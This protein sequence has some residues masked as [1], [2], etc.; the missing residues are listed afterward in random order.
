MKIL[1]DGSVFTELRR[2]KLV[3][4]WTAVL[5]SLST[6]QNSISVYLL[7]RELSSKF[8]RLA[9][10]INLYAPQVEWERSAL[11]D[12][13]LALLCKELGVDVFVSTYYTSAGAQV[14]SL[15]VSYDDL[16]FWQ[17][18]K[19]EWQALSEKRARNLACATWIVPN[20]WRWEKASAVTQFIDKLY[21]AHDTPLSAK[22]LERRALEEDL[23]IHQA[24][25][26]R[27]VAIQSAGTSAHHKNRKAP[28]TSFV[29]RLFKAVA[30]PRCYPEYGYR[31]ICKVREKW[32]RS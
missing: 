29:P 10:V 2:G 28:T 7:N 24:N 32:F 5:T 25:A 4:F 18:P 19:T 8:A 17:D 15:A 11:E 16:V 14:R 30:R 12:R 26:L 9:N 20:Y 1:V 3:N 31:I 22:E 6:R 27:A 23:T 21:A 13:R